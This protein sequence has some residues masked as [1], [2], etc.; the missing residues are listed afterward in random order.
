MALDL[1]LLFGISLLA[2]I[3]ILSVNSWLAR[4]RASYNPQ[5]LVLSM[6]APLAIA[7]LVAER[8][9]RREQRH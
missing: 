8:R 9:V 7:S 2:L 5:I 4:V 6:L 1:A 3:L